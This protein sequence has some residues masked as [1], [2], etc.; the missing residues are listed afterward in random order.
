M[1]L[2]LYA[3]VTIA[4]ILWVHSVHAGS[5]QAYQDY[6][7]QFDLY[8][9]KYNEFT[10]ARGEYEKFKSLGSQSSAIT[11][12][13]AMMIQ[14]SMLIRSYLLLLNEKINENPGI[15]DLQRPALHA[16]VNGE[17]KFSDDHAT[18]VRNVTTLEDSV[19]LSGLFD[20][21]YKDLQT[22]MYQSATSIALGNLAT[23]TARFDTTLSDAR[24]AKDLPQASFTPQK[25]AIIDRWLLQIDNTRNLLDQKVSEIMAKNSALAGHSSDGMLDEVHTMKSDMDTALTYLRSANGYLGELIEAMRYLD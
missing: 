5:Q 20:Q 17:I 1:R 14:R 21:H 8:R 24:T 7:Y 15:N 25:R 13:T 22:V 3:L 6:L 9:S 18:A 16:A 4:S 11:A 23:L 19:K 10:V 2:L 12:T